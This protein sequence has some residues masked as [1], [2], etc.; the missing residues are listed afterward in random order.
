[1]ARRRL[2]VED[3]E[4]IIQVGLS[5]LSAEDRSSLIEECLR[6]INVQNKSIESSL[7]LDENQIWE[8]IIQELEK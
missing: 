8:K 1:M 7:V 4:S 6:M 2:R 5:Q 3:V